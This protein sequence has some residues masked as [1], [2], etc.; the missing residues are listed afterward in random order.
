MHQS[1]TLT[2]ITA[3]MHEFIDFETWVLL[4]SKIKQHPFGQFN[5]KIKIHT[6]KTTCNWDFIHVLSPKHLTRKK[7]QNSEWFEEEKE[8]VDREKAMEGEWEEH[9]P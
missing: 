3:F 5:F 7:D 1:I 4:K 6:K 2:Q 9:L 8:D